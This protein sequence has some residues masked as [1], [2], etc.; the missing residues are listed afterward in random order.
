VRQSTGMGLRDLLLDTGKRFYC[1]CFTC[2]S[3]STSLAN[4]LVHCGLGEPFEH[5]QEPRLRNDRPLA[6]TICELV[7]AS[8]SSVF[9][10]KIALNQIHSLTTRLRREGDL[11]AT[12][13]LRTIFPG[14]RFVSVHRTDKV[15]QA[16]S[17]WRAVMTDQWH[18]ESRA[19]VRLGRPEYDF[20]AIKEVL[21]AV[22]TEDWLWDAYFSANGIQCHQ[23]VYEEYLQ[24]RV[25]TLATLLDFLGVE[26]PPV[27][28]VL[29]V[30][31]IMRDDWTEHLVERVWDDLAAQSFRGLQRGDLVASGSF[32]GA[33][34]LS[35]FS[36]LEFL[37]PRVEQDRDG[38]TGV[39]R[40]A[41]AG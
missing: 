9:G 41:E 32:D 37:L 13:D 10:F 12:S 23:V 8:D 40:A 39:D 14:L 27:I 24:D 25:S 29:D 4:D 31:N 19:P 22:V 15:A 3:G 16:V 7:E 11:S 6:R 5:F 2:R 20:D 28:P 33:R 38:L 17:Y 21:L 30:I 26:R 18:V 35:N 34:A 1:V 36:G